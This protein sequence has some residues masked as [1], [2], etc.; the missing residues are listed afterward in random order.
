MSCRSK[1]ICGW[2]GA[3]LVISAMVSKE[4]PLNIVVIGLVMYF[5]Y[6]LEAVTGDKTLL[7]LK[8][9][10]SGKAL[11]DYIAALQ[12]AE[13]GIKLVIQ[14]YHDEKKAP[15]LG[16]FRNFCH[17]KDLCF[18]L[19]NLCFCLGNLL[20]TKDDSLHFSRGMARS[21]RSQGVW[22]H[23]MPRLSMTSMVF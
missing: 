15:K 3:G 19:G 13:P 6:L 11:K 8:N 10:K 7:Y 20:C 21:W 23:I 2:C 1:A 5:F 9:V 16:C 4:P 14:N 22:T 17:L 18:C 12:E